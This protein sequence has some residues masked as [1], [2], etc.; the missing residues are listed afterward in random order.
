MDQGRWHIGVIFLE[1]PWA[2]QYFHHLKFGGRYSASAIL[3]LKSTPESDL[4]GSDLDFGFYN[5]EIQRLLNQA[6]IKST[7]C[8]DP[9]SWSLL[10][11]PSA[12]N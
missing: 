1:S 11:K 8:L 3:L 5:L 10:G 4:F 2:K 7:C 9:F 6:F 12:F